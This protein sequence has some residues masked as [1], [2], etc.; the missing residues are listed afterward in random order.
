[1]SEKWRSWSLRLTMNARKRLG[2]AASV[3]TLIPDKI[4]SATVT[5][6]CVTSAKSHKAIAFCRG[7]RSFLNGFTRTLHTSSVSEL[8]I[9]EHYRASE[10][11]ELRFP[12]ILF[13][14]LKLCSLCLRFLS[15]T[16]AKLPP[17]HVRKRQQS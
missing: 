10:Q 4:I 11:L 17:M 6:Y 15:T 14:S 3:V 16:L 5:N 12:I 7:G 9:N 2:A 13:L 8:G 1:M